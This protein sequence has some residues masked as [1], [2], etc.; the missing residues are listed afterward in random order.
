MRTLNLLL[1]AAPPILAASPAV[2]APFAPAS[3]VLVTSGEAAAGGTFSGFGGLSLNDRGQV[4]F[5]AELAGAD[6]SAGS[7]VFRASTSVEPQTIA[8]SG[9]AAGGA[10]GT[11]AA[12]LDT[13]VLNRTGTVY[14]NASLTGTPGGSDDD[15]GIY[16]GSGVT[17][18]EIAREGNATPNADGFFSRFNT[19]VVVNAREQVAFFSQL[20]DTPRRGFDNR[21]LYRFDPGVGLVEVIRA[22]QPAPSGVGTLS[23]SGSAGGITTDGVIST[24]ASFGN[25][26]GNFESGLILAEKPSNQAPLSVVTVLRE[27]DP[28]PSGGTFQFINTESF[29]E[30]GQSAFIASVRPPNSFDRFGIFRAEASGQV[31]QIALEDRT[32]PGVS[33]TFERFGGESLNAS[34]QVAFTADTSVG[35]G[36][37]VSNTGSRLTRIARGG[38]AAPDADGGTNGRF[39]DFASNATGLDSF[40]AP[41][42]NDAGQLAFYS[43]LTGTDNGTEDDAGIFFYDPME[44]LFEVAREGDELLGSTISVLDVNDPNPTFGTSDQ[45]LLNNLGQ[46]AFRFELADG[47][48]GLALWSI[49]EPTTGLLAVTGF[50]A[51]A[52]RRR[53]H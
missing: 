19:E 20:R 10:G 24:R 49:P 26:F 25:G 46:V 53:G 35:S 30:A 5:L 41:G 29:N 9:G 27:D 38:Q 39:A 7:G 11:F 51:L 17:P 8:R 4:S 12:F 47:R 15:T 2:A 42:L 36:V 34:G 52:T 33:G 23:P 31:T 6:G 1:L 3:T 22:N 50:A 13:P 14:F 48:E 21:G 18:F 43:V 44:G 40:G 16:A 45:A 32:Q 37:F 28:A